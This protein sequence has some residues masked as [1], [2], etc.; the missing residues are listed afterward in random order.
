MAAVIA[1]VS[2]AID[3]LVEL[4]EQAQKISLIV[5][6]QQAAGLTTLTADQWASIVGDDDSAEAALTQAIAAAKAAGK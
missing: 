4:I 3:L 5:Q 6:T 2:A 1:E